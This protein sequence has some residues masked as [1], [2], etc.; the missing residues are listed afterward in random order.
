MAKMHG[1][2]EFRTNQ[3]R[4]TRE[5]TEVQD[6]CY[7]VVDDT[8]VLLG[9]VKV[10]ERILDTEDADL[11]G[12]LIYQPVPLL[13]QQGLREMG[14]PAPSFAPVFRVGDTPWTPVQWPLTVLGA[15]AVFSIFCIVNE[16]RTVPKGTF[17]PGP[18]LVP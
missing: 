4:T 11:S 3:T 16:R 6:Y 14:L 5:H 18:N 13:I 8:G 7:P 17:S 1:A 2:I 12:V 15:V 10:H 9:L